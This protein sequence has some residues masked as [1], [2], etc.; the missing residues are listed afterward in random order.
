MKNLYLTAALKCVPPGDK[1]TSVELKT[2]SQYFRKEMQLLQKINTIV[3][4][5]KIAFDACLNFYKQ[6][7][8]I[9]NKNFIFKHGGQYLLPDNKFLIASYHPSP[10]NVNT[11]RIDLSKMVQLLMNI[12]KIIYILLLTLFIY[13]ANA[14]NS[15]S[16]L[17]TGT[18]S[19]L[20]KVQKDIEEGKTDRAAMTSWK[21]ITYWKAQ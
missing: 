1:P 5:G 4:L 2:C 16:T 19:V 20:N 10:R 21:N 17:Q 8:N 12:K 3:A 6:D 15:T 18:Y 13:A 11:G 7:F 9:Q 14:G